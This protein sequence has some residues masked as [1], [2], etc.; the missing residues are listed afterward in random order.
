MPVDIP[1]ETISLSTTN[2]VM[3]LNSDTAK[4]T[5]VSPTLR[6]LIFVGINF[7]EFR[8]V[9]KIS[10]KLL[11]TV[12]LVKFAKINSREMRTFCP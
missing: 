10:R 1:C 7:H 8:E 11:V 3:V 5:V 6:E 2:N 4:N 12:Q 9:L